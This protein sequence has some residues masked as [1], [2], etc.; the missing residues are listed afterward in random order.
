[1]GNRDQETKEEAECLEIALGEWGCF[2]IFLSRG[3]HS[4]PGFRGGQLWVLG[5]VLKENREISAAPGPG[6]AG[7]R[8]QQPWAAPGLA[9]VDPTGRQH[10]KG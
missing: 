8:Q 4:L 3:G 5:A 6:R 9:W 1:M 10:K 7:G 2:G